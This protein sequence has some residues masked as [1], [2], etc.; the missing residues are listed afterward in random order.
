M[1]RRSRTTACLGSTR[2]EGRATKGAEGKFETSIT[3]K[4]HLVAIVLS[5]VLVGAAASARGAQLC[6]IARHNLLQSVRTGPQ[7]RVVPDAGK[8]FCRVWSRCM[9]AR[10]STTALRKLP[11]HLHGRDA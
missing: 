11:G 10:P 4:L 7:T 1:G 2:T 9:N 6:R 8:C 3:L 5:L